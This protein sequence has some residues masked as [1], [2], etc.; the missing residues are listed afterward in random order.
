[1]SCCCT[2][3]VDLGCFDY[4]EV[5]TLTGYL[6]A[7]TG[8]HTLEVL[9]PM[10][11]VQAENIT[12]TATNTLTIPAALLNESGSQDIKLKQPDGTYYA[13]SSGVDCARITTQVH[14]SIGIVT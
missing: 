8:V 9:F 11:T 7:Q 12:Y 5:I 10:D 1:M 6:A 14:T 13:W 4:C 3:Y 2:E